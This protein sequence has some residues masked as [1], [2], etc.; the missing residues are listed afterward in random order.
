MNRIIS[1]LLFLI[2]FCLGVF[3]AD[4]FIYGVECIEMERSQQNA[5]VSQL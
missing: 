5:T 1:V 2:G 3:F 4:K